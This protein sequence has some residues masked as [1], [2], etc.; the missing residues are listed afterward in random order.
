MV[1]LLELRESLQNILG[2]VDKLKHSTHLTNYHNGVERARDARVAHHLIIDADSVVVDI[3]HGDPLSPYLRARFPE[4]QWR[5]TI[6]AF[7]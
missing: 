3:W 1:Q 2:T 5:V 7:P 6:L 4:F